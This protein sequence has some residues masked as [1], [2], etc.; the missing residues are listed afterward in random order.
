MHPLA[1]WTDSDL[2]T[3]RLACGINLNLKPFS[4]K[5]RMDQYFKA[6]LEACIKSI[7]IGIRPYPTTS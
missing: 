3:L 5:Q 2:D 1:K 7:F 4:Y 6:L